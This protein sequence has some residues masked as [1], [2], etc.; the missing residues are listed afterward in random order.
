M[1]GPTTAPRSR[2]GRRG[3]AVPKNRCASARSCH[4]C[5]VKTT[6]D[7]E[8][9]LRRWGLAA[10][11][12]APAAAPSSAAAL[13]LEQ[14][15]DAGDLDIR[16]TNLRSGDGHVLLL[17]FDDPGGFPNASAKA[18]HTARIPAN[19]GRVTHLVPGLAAGRYAVTVVHDENDNKKLDKNVFGIPKE[20]WG[21]SRNPRPRTR[22]PRWSESSF[23]LEPGAKKAVS[24]SLLYP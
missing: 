13:S 11:L 17:V 12:V 14:R 22:A 2:D 9:H 1:N 6:R 20:G 16:L 18:V 24:I 15:A 5:R 7:W 4:T 3:R 23:A 21:T 19:K 10:L 8:R